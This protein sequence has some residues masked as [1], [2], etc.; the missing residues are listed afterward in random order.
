MIDKSLISIFIPTGNRAKSLKKVLDS[1]SIQTYKK[2]EILIVDYKSTD[3]TPII[4]SDYVNKLQIKF[5]RQE[6]K[7]LVHSIT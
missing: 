1:L 3:E 6:K 4:I 7:G 2:F 5:I